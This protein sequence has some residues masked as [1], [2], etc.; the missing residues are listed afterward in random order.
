MQ[1]ILPTS[2]RR[3]ILAAGIALA[4]A[5]SATAADYTMRISHQ[6]P[7]THHTALNLDQFAKDVKEATKGNA[8]VSIYDYLGADHGFNRTPILAHQNSPT[9]HTRRALGIRVQPP[10]WSC[11]FTDRVQG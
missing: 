11:A 8:N 3:Q 5:G 6:F 10:C 2:T 1:K 9:P 7:P 4:M